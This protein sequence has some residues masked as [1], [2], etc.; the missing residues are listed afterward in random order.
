MHQKKQKQINLG[1]KILEFNVWRFAKVLL[2]QMCGLVILRYTF[3][4]IKTLGTVIKA[5]D[6]KNFRITAKQFTEI[7]KIWK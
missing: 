1:E 3:T 5:P 6:F 4:D 2:R 7:A